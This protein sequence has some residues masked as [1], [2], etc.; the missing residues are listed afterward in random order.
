MKPNSKTD[1]RLIAED[2]AE[3]EKRLMR[4][5]RTNAVFESQIQTAMSKLRGGK[6]FYEIKHEMQIKNPNIWDDIQ[7]VIS[8]TV[9]SPEKCAI[10]WGFRL[11]SQYQMAADLYKRAKEKQDLKAEASAILLMSRLT[12][13]DFTLKRELGLIKPLVTDDDGSGYSNEDVQVIDIENEMRKKLEERILAKM[14]LQRSV[15]EPK[16]IALLDGSNTEQSTNSMGETTLVET[17]TN[18]YE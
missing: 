16:P 5:R 2:K 8:R 6:S 14:E 13:Q 18:R 15:E 9:Y 11:N 7:Y 3:R 12:E 10:E 4:K 17:N 1:F